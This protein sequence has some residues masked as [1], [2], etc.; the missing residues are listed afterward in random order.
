M[1]KT[2]MNAYKKKKNR[3]YIYVVCLLIA[4]VFFLLVMPSV[5][6][7]SFGTSMIAS[8][9]SHHLKGQVTIK[10]I[11]LG[12]FT[13]QHIEGFEYKGQNGEDFFS[14]QN[15]NIADPLWNL[16][17]HSKEH[18]L[19]ELQG[20]VL[21]IKQPS[22]EKPKKKKSHKKKHEENNHSMFLLLVEN[23]NIQ[24]AKVSLLT[25]KQSIQFENVD[26]RLKINNTKPS[27]LLAKGKTSFNDTNGNFD[28]ESFF[29]KDAIYKAAVTATNFPICGVDELLHFEGLLTETIGPTLNAEIN[30]SFTQDLFNISMEL[31][32][33][34]FKTSFH[35]TTLD[36]SVALVKPASISLP[37][38]PI[39]FQQIKEVFKLEKSL[40]MT[41]DGALQVAIETLN[42]PYEN[43]SLKLK[44]LAYK[45]R[46]T[47]SALAFAFRDKTE[48]VS[49]DTFNINSSTK[50]LSNSIDISLQS[51]F[52]YLL[53]NPSYVN[54]N[55]KIN[56]VFSKRTFTNLNVDIVKLPLTFLTNFIAIDPILVDV[57]GDS[58]TLKVSSSKETYIAK[59]DTPRLQI[60]ELIISIE[61][62]ISIK[63]EAV[64]TYTPS[65]EIITSYLSSEHLKIAKIGTIQGTLESFNFYL[66]DPEHL[67]PNNFNLLLRLKNEAIT[68]NSSLLPGVFTLKNTGFSVI[69]DNLNHFNIETFTGVTYFDKSNPENTLFKDPLKINI[70]AILDLKR[71]DALEI[72]SLSCKFQNNKMNGSFL[73][74]IQEN[75]TKVVFLKPLE[76]EILPSSEIMNAWTNSSSD[77]I[78]YVFTLPIKASCNLQPIYLNKPLLENLSFNAQIGLEKFDLIDK[79][80]F[81]EFSFLN[82]TSTIQADSKK[83]Q[84]LCN[85]ESHSLSKEAPDGVFLCQLSS[86]QFNSF[87]F[88]KDNTQI[89]LSCKGIPSSLID[90]LLGYKQALNIILGSTFESN[91]NI[92]CKETG[93]F[94]KSNVLSP[95]VNFSGEF[96]ISNHVLELQTPL[97]LT[98]K[99]TEECH[100]AFEEIF[101]G[102]PDNENFELAEQALLQITTKKL[103]WP[104]NQNLPKKISLK[105]KI[106]K[107]AEHLDSSFFYVVAKTNHMLIQSNTNGE[108]TSLDDF[109][110]ECA[111]NNQQSPFVFN[112]T[113]HVTN[114]TKD[115]N[116]EKG[117][118]TAAMTLQSTKDKQN[119]PMLV[120]KLDAK[121][122]HFP[123]MLIDSCF[124]LMGF[125]ELPPSLFLGK[126]INATLVTDLENLSGTIDF[127]VNSTDCKGNL[128]AFL[129]DGVVKLCKPIRAKM[130]LSPKLA[131][132]FLKSMDFDLSVAKN[133]IELFISEKGFYFPLDPFDLKKFQIRQANLNLG[134]IICTN[135]GNPFELSGVF[136]LSQDHRNQT[137]FWFAPMEFSVS[138]GY[139]SI[140]RTEVL[141]NN[142]YQIAFWGKVDIVP[143]VVDMILGITEQSLRKAFG[144]RGLPKSFVLQIP[145]G[146]PI[147]KV[148]IK[149]EVA[150]A[151][152]AILIAKTTGLDQGGLWGGIVNALSD[153]ANDQESVPAAKPP[154]PWH[155]ALSRYEEEERQSKTVN[156]IK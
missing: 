14:F 24:N 110:L 42:I 125:K 21:N 13:P 118:I 52:S 8:R 82:T 93:S 64:F 59:L 65:D 20:P 53:K 2:K 88:L 39:L 45:G 57:L 154:F 38:T 96:S 15:L 67:S 61:K 12:W 5:I 35:T 34:N 122:S 123:T 144:I 117:H 66:K 23:F 58:V 55:F 81:K 150:T 77:M 19:I 127:D 121:L 104:L 11:Q 25:T 102:S 137:A 6:S 70:A 94:I 73:A 40:C 151:R 86:N 128:N 56:D 155:E 100:G 146:G 133:P 140:D 37:L 85:I 48:P 148:K 107:V 74:T 116:N 92:N 91:F 76:V 84:F 114:K 62:S 3:W 98:I 95:N 50:D 43:R 126:R 78:G 17:I 106:S 69:A 135:Y 149:T 27:S 9:L 47:S 132:V 101:G 115:S 109:V 28:I 89:T 60:P 120:S 80:S 136:K 41:R 131:D 54:T 105:E 36:K 1:D 22:Q 108:L 71:P 31:L 79:I 143:K 16:L 139:L 29:S 153:M 119:R 145:M 97:E 63:Q 49:I 99:L 113:S 111:K 51:S 46:L 103:Y 30:C 44:H 32:S 4:L 112:L 152:I 141:F 87:D 83:K 129:T 124:Q 33:A 138:N 7:S 68:L 18:G 156:I 130:N 90:T 147:G 72:P 26:L 142:A 10:K 75:L 134:Q